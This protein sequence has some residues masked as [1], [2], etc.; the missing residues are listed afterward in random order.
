VGQITSLFVHK[1]I[2]QVD[3]TL[4][5]RALLE[6][7]P[8]RDFEKP[9]NVELIKVDTATGLKAVPGRASRME[10]FV[11]GTEPKRFA[12]SPSETP[13]EDRE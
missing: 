11:A 2:R 8:P 1:V 6:G 5:K 9:A 12:P 10:V 3:E 4:D 13:E 7:L